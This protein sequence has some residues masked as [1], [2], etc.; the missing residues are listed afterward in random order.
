MNNLTKDGEYEMGYPDYYNSDKD[1]KNYSYYLSRYEPNQSLHPYNIIIVTNPST[2]VLFDGT[3]HVHETEMRG[4]FIETETE[5]L[6]IDSD[7]NHEIIYFTV[8]DVLKEPKSI[9]YSFKFTI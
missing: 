8:P 4:K 6:V 9:K 2:E 3:L 5:G 7:N 1:K